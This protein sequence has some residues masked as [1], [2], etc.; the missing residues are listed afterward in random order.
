MRS[1]AQLRLERMKEFLN[2]FGTEHKFT[3]LYNPCDN[4]FVE[5]VNIVSRYTIR[6]A[7]KSELDRVK[8][9]KKAV[10]AYPIAGNESFGFQS[11][12]GNEVKKSCNLCGWLHRAKVVF[13]TP[14]RE[15]EKEKSQNSYKTFSNDRTGVVFTEMFPRQPVRV[16]KSGM[17]GK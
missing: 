12:W 7:K 15:G 9:L 2:G 6:L 1:Y 3:S 11:T 4:G 17:T 13:W 8:E 5:I 10:R 14:E 16:K